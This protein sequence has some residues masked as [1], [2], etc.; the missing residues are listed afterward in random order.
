MKRRRWRVIAGNVL[1]L[2]GALH[3][4]GYAV[5]DPYADWILMKHWTQVFT[6][7]TLTLLLILIGQTFLA[8]ERNRGKARCP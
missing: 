2:A 5:F 8:V 7:W 4:M 1:T 3:V 6:C